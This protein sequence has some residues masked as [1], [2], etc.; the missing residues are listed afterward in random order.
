MRFSPETMA[1]VKNL[2]FALAERTTFARNRALASVEPMVFVLR[3]IA[4]A[5]TEHTMFVRMNLAFDF[6]EEPCLC[7]GGT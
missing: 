7:I 2:A 1:F 6:C 4:L 5:L 3:D